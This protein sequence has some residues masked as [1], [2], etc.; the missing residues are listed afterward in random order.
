MDIQM[1][2]MD[3]LQAT[4]EI[5]KIER[6]RGT[7]IPIVGLSGNALQ[8]HMEEARRAGMDRF[9]TKP[10]TSSELLAALEVGAHSSLASAQREAS[11]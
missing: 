9:V 7:H 6:E 1:P 3:G 11:D 4:I 10:F 8:Q 2:E 5:R